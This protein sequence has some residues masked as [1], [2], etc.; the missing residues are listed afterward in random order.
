MGAGLA[1]LDAHGSKEPWLSFTIPGGARGKGRPKFARTAKG[2]R[3]YNDEKTAAYEGLVAH[4]AMQVLGRIQPTGQPVIL[5]LVIRMTPPASA[6][7]RKRAEMLAGERFPIVKPDAS[8][9]LKAVEDGLNK[10]AYGD[11]A[12]IV[13]I[14]VSKVYDEIPGVDACVTLVGDAP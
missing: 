10:V 4:A 6:S 3:T 14:V 5:H 7:K 13:R 8:N 9:V 11:D 2:V 1:I 12:Q